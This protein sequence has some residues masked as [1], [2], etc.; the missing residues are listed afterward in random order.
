MGF[1]SKLVGAA[2]PIVGGIVG[3]PAGAAIGSGIG[4]ALSTQDAQNF[5][6]AEASASRG[7][8]KEQ[9]QNRHQWEVADLRA[10]GLNPI[11][12]AMKG[13]PSIGGSAAATSSATVADG[14]AKLT[15]SA[16]ASKKLNAEISL[17]ESQAAAARTQGVKNLADAKNVGNISDISQNAANIS[18][19]LHSASASASKS[20]NSGINYISKNKK[21]LKKAPSSYWWALRN[22]KAMYNSLKGN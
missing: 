19:G 2:A 16:L 14:A 9:L 1:L 7:F 4:G 8:T 15:Q 13:A 10:A 11:L 20:I 3:G 12:S 18:K 5:S 21:K 17:I 22:P 6:S